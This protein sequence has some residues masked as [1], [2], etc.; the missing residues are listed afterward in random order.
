[1]KIKLIA[2]ISALVFAFSCNI[3]IA[4]AGYAELTGTEYVFSADPKELAFQSY[5][6]GITDNL[7]TATYVKTTF[8]SNSCVKVIPNTESEKGYINLDG[9]NYQGAGIDVARHATVVMLYK[10]VSDNPVSAIPEL[11]LMSSGIFTKATTMFAREGLVANRWAIASFDLTLARS[12]IK[13]DGT[14]IVKQF[15]FLP[16]G[17]ADVSKLSEGDVVYVSKMFVFPE[18]S[19]RAEYRKHY[20]E[21]TYDY[22]GYNIFNG[23]GFIT[24]AEACIMISRIYADGDINIPA[25]DG[26]SRYSDVT[27]H[28]AA[29]YIEYLEDKGFLKS[30]TEKKFSPDEPVTK[31]EFAELTQYLEIYVQNG[32][33]GFPSD[34]AD[35]ENP[36][37]VL[38]G[39]SKPVSRAEAVFLINGIFGRNPGEPF[40]QYQSKF[41]DTIKGS[42][43]YNH[44]L[45]AALDHITLVDENGNE[46]WARGL[47]NAN[48][49]ENFSPDTITGKAEY[50]KAIALMNQRIEEIRATDS[51]E[52]D[53]KG[54]TYYVSTYGSD[55][56]DGLSE[57]SPFKT[58]T[59]ASEVAKSGDLV[60]FERGCEWRERWM[61]VQG[62]TYSAY[63]AGAKP[64]FNGN[65]HGDLAN[66][67]Y[68]TLVD[69]TT[70]VYKLN[71]K[72][73]DVG[74]IV[75]TKNG[76]VSTVT[77]QT[78]KLSGTD[79]L[80]NNKVFD[81]TTSMTSNN[82]FI[83][84]YDKVSGSNV[85][86]DDTDTTLYFRCYYGNPGEYYD[87]IE[88]CER[89]SL[90]RVLNNCHL[91]NIEIKYTG[92]HGFAM[93][94]ANNVKFTNC[95]ISYI[96][97][98]AQYYNNGSMVRFGNGIE[99]YGSTDGFIIDN[100]YVYQCYDAGITHQYSEG[101]TVKVTH[102][103]VKYTN[104]VLDKCIY[105][106]EY[107]MGYSENDNAER[108][109]E[110]I[111][112][113]NNILARNG[114][115]WGY[116][117]SRSGGIVGWGHHPN[118]AENFVIEDNTFITEYY[119]AFFLGAETEEDLPTFRNNTYFC[120]YNRD[121]I[122]YGIIDNTVTY[123]SNGKI[124]EVLEKVVEEENPT[125]YYY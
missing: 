120:K 90:V 85:T 92:S 107:F 68:W 117:P 105:N 100:C 12:T 28:N 22:E 52:F 113:K 121:Y 61:T 8:E 59:K 104:N 7:D 110:N 64:V 75:L 58:A 73:K 14:S 109:M 32:K 116:Y 46:F 55:D 20:I 69:G 25:S 18:E 13:A 54:K 93:G 124:T 34:F 27:E 84:I 47:G 33:N 119:R 23:A 63:G 83:C 57:S 72:V 115:G 114:R 76:T 106:I 4:F 111:L 9:Y 37:S 74:N 123:K 78:P 21:G 99:V 48:A 16:L 112:Y 70:N 79:H 5:F 96:G 101:G 65:T 86:L 66:K 87:S 42:P 36:E 30:Y 10:Y 50:D 6:C 51:P 103:N 98:S 41:K 45:D 81:P 49:A 35:A 31:A 1:M 60:L 77:K 11:R 89:G 71:I 26:K 44:I 39:K 80:F 108:S 67:N 38:A 95:E 3:F 122:T 94:T 125:V 102:K 2:F 62:V 82:S 118:R 17:L 43:E 24:R 88:I 53:I 97:G 19:E 56:N 15:H 91:D 40:V 29:K